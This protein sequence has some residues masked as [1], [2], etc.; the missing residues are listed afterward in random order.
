MSYAKQEAYYSRTPD[1][2]IVGGVRVSHS[3]FSFLYC[4][5]YLEGI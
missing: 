5:F 4:V 2:P 1:P 3:V